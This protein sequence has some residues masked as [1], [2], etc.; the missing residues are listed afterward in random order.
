[1]SDSETNNNARYKEI[2]KVTLIGSAVDLSLGVAKIIVGIVGSSQAL[3]ADGIHSLSDLV[4][5][6]MVLF[7][8]KQAS[9]PADEE[10]PYG[11]ARIETVMT[12]ALGI[13][14]I[15]V[16]TG[17]AYDAI[18]RLFDPELLL[19]PGW[20]ALVVAAISIVSKEAIYRY[21]SRTA[22][23]LRSNLLHANAWHS[24]SDA[25]SSVIVVI[26]VAGSMAGLDYLDAV[27][28]IGVAAMIVKIG[29]DLVWHSLREL[30]DT[31]LEPE[32]VD[33]ISEC[34]RS[35]DGV[36]TTHM[37][38]TRKMGADALVDVHIQVGPRLSVSEGHQI[39]ETVRARIIHDIEE[40]TDVL[41]HIDPEDDEQATPCCTLPLR[42]SLMQ[43][44]QACWQHIEAAAEVENV[45]VHYLGGKVYLEVLLPLRVL[46]SGQ[47]ADT[48]QRRFREVLEDQKDIGGIELLFH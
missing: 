1:M 37:L 34:I 20:G 44:V 30:V 28:A 11:H 17:I 39:S 13:A 26:G 2:R 42:H 33:A 5:D 38:R 43:R 46:Q 18:R 4:T 19:H 23:R 15:A 41:V 31:G 8:A 36:L 48:L 24:R 3:L 27:A 32:R 29:W 45:T 14:L 7:A 22:N 12:V 9:H 47:N 21:T 6:F 40:V 25:I 16:A 10:H 35:V